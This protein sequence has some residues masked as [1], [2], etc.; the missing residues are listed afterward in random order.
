MKYN[1]STSEFGRATASGRPF[2]QTSRALER[3]VIPVGV[4][5]ALGVGVGNLSAPKVHSHRRPAWAWAPVQIA[6]LVVRKFFS[7][8]KLIDLH[9]DAVIG[10]GLIIGHGGPIR[11]TVTPK[12]EPT[13]RFIMY[14][15]S[16][17][18]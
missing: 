1:G 15:P 17:R 6:L 14:V 13:A 18:I 8:C 7:S 9:P 12:S 16:E 5:G 2:A 10:P 11:I 4:G 3:T